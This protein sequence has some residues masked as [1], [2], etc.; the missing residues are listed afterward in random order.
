M[1]ETNLYAW[2]IKW[3]VCAAALQ[4]LRVQFNMMTDPDSETRAAEGSEGR[5]QADVRIEASEKGHRLWRNNVGVLKDERGVP[6]RFGLCNDSSKLN[7]LIK[8]GD[9]IGIRQRVV[10]PEDVGTIIG[11][12]MSREVKEPGWVYSGSG[13]EPAQLRWVETVN[14]LGGDAAFATGCGTI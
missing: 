13:R 5:A 2:A 9:L 7:K 14:A 4:D 1:S 12:F 6:V 3:G 8:S 11:Q 10:R